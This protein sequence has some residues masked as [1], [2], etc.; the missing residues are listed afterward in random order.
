MLRYLLVTALLIAATPAWAEA[1]YP[2]HPIML[3]VPFGA[4]SG[5]DSMARELAQEL[6]SDLGQRVFVENKPGASGMIAVE[7]VAH[8]A[9]DGYTLLMAGN[10]TQSANPYL[11]KKIPYDPIKDFT[12]IARL[13]TAPFVLVVSPKGPFK[14]VADIVK[15]AKAAP[16]KLTY[17]APSS[18]AIVA[19]EMLKHKA[20][21][22]ITQVRYKRTPQ[23]M[24]DV[25]GKVTSMAFVDLAASLT[26]IRGGNLRALVTT[27]AHRTPLLPDLPTMAE[28][29]FPGTNIIAWVG[30]F[31]PAHVP[32]AVRAKLD[33]AVKQLMT[34]A[35]IQKRLSSMG[36]DPA[37]MPTNETEAFVRTELVRWG[38]MIHQAGIQ[39][40]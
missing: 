31:A 39:P 36:L 30:V 34:N 3:V 27:G 25:M 6:S 7:Y 1:N 4:G 35:K 24:T 12:P 22:D 19:G 17:G 14:T 23:A 10:T 2:T 37:Y 15:A 38:K 33:Q 28:S 8:A 40:Q 9:P 32:A 16:G 5:T 21:V 11:F 13:A 26:N 18:A 29:G 20:G